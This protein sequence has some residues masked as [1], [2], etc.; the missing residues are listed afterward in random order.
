MLIQFTGETEVTGTVQVQKREV[1]KKFGDYEKLPIQC[2]LDT[3][4]GQ[5]YLA[6][7]IFGPFSRRWVY[8]YTQAYKSSVS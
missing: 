3:H 8:T 4:C 2:K 7:F 1:S 5:S 6:K